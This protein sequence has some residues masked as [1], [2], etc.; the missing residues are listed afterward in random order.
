MKILY[1]FQGTGNGHIAR[2]QEIVPILKK[3]VSVDTLISGHQSQ[4]KAD[5]D[6]NFHYKGISLL[7]NKTGGLSY[8]KTFTDN[9]F[10]EAAKTI[11][12]ID[13]SGYDLIINDYEPITGW[14]S[15]LK[16]YPMIELSHQ[17]SMLFK[18]TPK[19]AKKDFL[20]ELVLKYYVPS[21][22]RIGFHF[23]NYH[24][25]IKK[26]VIRRKIR[27]LNPDKKGFYLVYLPSFSDE[28]IINVLKQIPV[29]WKIFSKY[30]KLQFKDGNVEVFPIDEIQYLKY[31]E[32]CDGI[33][34]NAGFETPAEALFMDK[35]LFV[36]PIHNQYEQECN[37]CALDKMGIPNSKVLKLEEIRNWVASDQH[38]K[39]NYPDDIEEILLNEVLTL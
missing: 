4:L 21:E 23:E 5:F 16:K 7:Y 20:G 33:L 30:S 9:N 35:K 34:C 32:N 39:V 25:Q 11:K 2:A 28:N 24:P 26:P 10:L 36:I 18:E 13:L 1:A 6:V 29:E 14:A 27:N 3:H 8:R 31:F 17:A 22:R 37:A 15:K 38:L 12:E 19:P